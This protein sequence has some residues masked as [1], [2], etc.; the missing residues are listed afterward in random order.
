M[1]LGGRFVLFAWRLRR[2]VRMAMPT[3]RYSIVYLF[4][5]FALL[6]ADHYVAYWQT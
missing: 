5:L 2:D 3:F 6:L 1:L 4:G